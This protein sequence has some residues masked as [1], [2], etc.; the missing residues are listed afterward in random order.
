MKKYIY[1]YISLAAFLIAAC[2][3]NKTI[4]KTTEDKALAGIIKKLEK[5]PADT[6]LRNTVTSLYIGA[7]KSHTD[8][9]ETYK[10][11]T[12]ADKWIKIVKEFEALQKLSAVISG[13]KEASKLF[14]APS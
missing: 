7:E 12:D 14:N 10:I 11:L 6:V 9:I 13:S 1:I 2:S 5:S 8:K 4:P 3:T